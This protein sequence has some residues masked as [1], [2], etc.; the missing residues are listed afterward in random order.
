[1]GE[2]ATTSGLHALL[3]AVDHYLPGFLPGGM[4]YGSLHGCVRDVS[5]VEGFLRGILKVP[6]DKIT[7]LS[8]TNPDV[9]RPTEPPETPPSYE[10]IVKAMMDLTARAAKGDQVFIHYSGHG[11]QA[12]T[13]YPARKGE[14]GVDETLVPYNIHDPKARYVRDLELAALLKAMTD[15]GLYVTLVFDC[16]HSGGATR[17][18]LNDVGVRGVDFIDMSERPTE[19]LV[20]LPETLTTRGLSKGE[21]LLPE[22]KGYTL[23]A[24][25]SPFEKALEFPF[26]GKEKNGAL[27]YWFLDAM[28]KIGPGLTYKMLHDRILTRIHS[29]FASQTPMLEGE[30]D[31][32]VFGVDKVPPIFA[33]LVMQVDAVGKQ[34][35]IGAGQSTGARKGSQ[36]AIYSQDSADRSSM[37]G[38]KAVVEIGVLGAVE[39]WATLVSPV[40]M[41]DLPIEQGDHAVLLG[42]G[43]ANLVRGIRPIRPD[44]TQY[45]DQDTPLKALEEALQTGG[46]GWVELSLEKPADFLVT[47]T[48]TGDAYEIC[49]RD[50]V[51][52]KNLRPPIKL[53]EQN[54][55][56]SVVKRLVHLAKYRAVRELD[57]FDDESKLKGKIVAELIGWQDNY[58][59]GD[60]IDPKPFPTTGG[61]VSTLKVGQTTWL[62]IRNELPAVPGQPELNV[63]N[64]TV[65]DLEP[66]W[67]ITQ[68]M[69]RRESI[70]S[71][72]LGPG[73]ELMAP[74]GLQLTANLPSG[75][76]EG[77]DT[78]KVLATVGPANFRVLELPALDQ[79][80]TR[81]GARARSVTRGGE[82]ALS[83]LLQTVAG[84]QPGTR[85]LD[86][87]SSPSDEWTMVQIEVKVVR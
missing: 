52:I 2:E 71:E 49:D 29:Q 66:S 14:T 41:P 15:K 84:D 3:I 47:L 35:K 55:A 4:S 37:A 68:V 87:S 64:V 25:C 54:A 1:M 43:S 75:Y 67:K 74:H 61:Q 24:A 57:N 19:S 16:C 65:L 76:T 33:A 36:F 72:P 30:P 9:G 83:R 40:A 59:K 80:G 62:R 81:G 26:D 53:S 22:P 23:L 28:R 38:R 70:D 34:V 10:N 50:G 44:G 12:K 85:S 46:S 27:T 8:S 82:T 6:A 7:K 78:L 20:T 63:L 48:K 56:A 69:P 18:E 21:G 32:V 39:S 5:H 58:T 77:S 13:I 17:G 86:P 79:P 42:S 51:P 73:K 11:G 45:T 31:R 60:K